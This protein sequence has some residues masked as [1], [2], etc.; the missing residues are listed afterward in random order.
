[1]IKR[2][3]LFFILF[4][5]LLTYG[6]SKTWSA[7]KA[8]EWYKKQGWIVGCNFLPSTAINQLEMWQAETFDTATINRELVWAESIGFNT[9]RVYLHD[10]AWKADPGGFKKRI[11]QFLSIA[12]KHKI[13]VLFTIFDDCWNP[14]PKIGKQPEPK[15]GIHNSGWMR[16]P[17]IDIHN[18]STQWKSLEEYVKDILGSFKNDKRVL[19][20]DLYNEPGNSGYELTSLPLLKK[21]F[22]WA[23]SIRPSQPLTSAIWYGNKTFNDFQLTNSDVI[24]FHNYNNAEDLEKEIND[25]LKK[26]RPV[27]CSEYMA[28]TRNSKFET[29]LPIFKKYNVGAINWGFVAGKSNT[30]YQ[31]DTP[32]PDGSEPTIWFHD[33]FRKNGTPYDEK[34]ISIIRQL[35]GIKEQ[36]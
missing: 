21:V 15:P 9:V 5:S 24:T 10:L 36:K 30:I 18:D 20:W 17:H 33:I 27:V 28:R 14:G 1:M 3:I 6:Q 35:T 25:L 8:N 11:N 2:I 12:A 34:E 29:H 7:K 13:K 31:W 23:W 4:S 16:S 26:G 32:V 19:M 22:E